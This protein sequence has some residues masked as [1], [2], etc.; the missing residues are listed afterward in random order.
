MPETVIQ[1]A[2]AL[3]AYYS[4]ARGESNVGVDVT[5]RRYVRRGRGDRP[6][7]VSYRNE[8]TVWVAADMYEEAEN[9]ADDKA[10]NP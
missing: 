8:H 2:A 7:L 1:K 6:G 10:G 3:A 5:E 9:G 4:P